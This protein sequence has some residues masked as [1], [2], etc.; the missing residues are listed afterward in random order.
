MASRRFTKLISEQQIAR[1]VEKLARQIDGYAGT[2]GI[3]EFTIICVMDGAFIFCA[4]LVRRMK[5]PTRIAFVKA[6]S[7]NGTKRGIT[8]LAAIPRNI[9]DRPVLVVDTIFDTGKTMERILRNVHKRASRVAIAILVVKQGKSE[10][11]AHT[12]GTDTFIGIRVKGDPFL[13]GYG[14]DCG[15]QFRHLRDIGVLR[16]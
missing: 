15:G 3:A 1:T 13:V 5:T 16:P 7:Y 6:R 8:S 14:L 12:Q 11:A 9:Q 2:N 4:D 10:L